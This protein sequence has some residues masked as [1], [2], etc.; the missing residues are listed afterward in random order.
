MYFFISVFFSFFLILFLHIALLLLISGH[1]ALME[2]VLKIQNGVQAVVLDLDGTLWTGEDVIDGAVSFWDTIVSNSV[3][4]VLL[5][6]TGERTR[7]DV[8]C[9]FERVLMRHINESQIWTAL[10]NIASFLD[11]IVSRDEMDTIYV[12]APQRNSAWRGFKFATRAVEYDPTLHGT[13]RG[14]RVC[15]AFLSDGKV[16]GDYQLLCAYVA[17]SISCDVPLYITS[18]DDTITLSHSNNVM[19][20]PGPGMFVRNVSSLLRSVDR[21]HNL[22]RFFGKGSDPM[23]PIKAVQLLNAM[24]YEGPRE[25]IHFI[26]DRLDADV[27]AAFQVGSTAVHV[28]SGCHSPSLYGSFPNDVPHIV[29]RDVRELVDMFDLVDDVSKIRN[30]IRDRMFSASHRIRRGDL[31]HFLRNTIGHF[32][33]MPPRRIQSSPD[34][35]LLGGLGGRTE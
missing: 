23:M 17:A 4:V 28:E 1:M 12:I 35:A 31:G 33:R 16:D 20:C 18:D 26:G 6:N 24:G 2:S 5:S 32:V 11:D 3:K 34:L 21:S 25:L 13:L 29:A 30:F 14:P 19:A 7:K 10:E 22:I 27:R 9:K 15:I 8:Q